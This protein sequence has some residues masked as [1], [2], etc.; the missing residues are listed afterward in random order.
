MQ[1]TVC[2]LAIFMLLLSAGCQKEPDMRVDYKDFSEVPRQFVTVV[3]EHNYHRTHNNTIENRIDVS[4]VDMRDLSKLKVRDA[5][6]LSVNNIEAIERV[7]NFIDQYFILGWSYTL[8]Q[9]AD[10][11]VDIRLYLP[12]TSEG[13]DTFSTQ[14]AVPTLSIIGMPAQITEGTNYTLTWAGDPLAAN[15]QFSIVLND[16][17]FFSQYAPANPLNFNAPN[18][19]CHSEGNYFTIK[20]TRNFQPQT[21]SLLW[22]ITSTVS[23]SRN[24]MT[25]GTA[26]DDDDDDNISND[27]SSIWDDDDQ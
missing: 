5:A 17:V 11:G 7:P 10:Y 3:V 26:C 19:L 15:E 27:N 8:P 2:F 1:K 18:N 12:T 25:N 14:F 20:R 13:V 16:D 4:F 6:R 23:H 9:S 22:N 24:I 21:S